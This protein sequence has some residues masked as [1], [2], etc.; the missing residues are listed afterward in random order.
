MADSRLGEARSCDERARFYAT[1]RAEIAG[2]GERSLF[3]YLKRA[4]DRIFR[5]GG[6]THDAASLL[7]QIGSFSGHRTHPCTK[8]RLMLEAGTGPG[9]HPLSAAEFAAYAPEAAPD[10]SLPVLAVARDQVTQ[11][12]SR[13]L[14][15]DYAGFFAQSFPDAHRAWAASVARLAGQGAPDRFVPIPIHPLQL[16]AIQARFAGPIAAGDILTGTGAAIVQRPTISFRTFSPVGRPAE[17]QVKTTLAILMTSEVRILSPARTFNAPVL[18]DLLLGIA[19][20]DGRLAGRFRLQP[21][22]AAVAWGRD[23]DPAS[24]DYRDGYHLGVILRR[25]P[26]PLLSAGEMA[27]PLNTLLSRSPAP[28]GAM[29]LTE[30]MREAGVGDSAAALA[31]FRHYAGIVLGVTLWMLARYG[32]SIEAHQQNTDLVFDGSGRLAALAYRD[33]SGGMEICEPMLIAAGHDIRPALHP[34]I[35]SLCGGIGLPI[36]QTMHTTFVSHL[37]PVSRLI[38]EDFGTGLP[39]LLAAMKEIIL[40]VLGDARRDLA[41]D[42]GGQAEPLFHDALAAIE[43]RILHAPVETKGLLQMR[44]A[45]SHDVTF[46]AIDNPLAGI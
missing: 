3:G 22:P 31:W 36:Q 17:P 43:Q 6:A 24:A 5:L 16:P 38:A 40:A 4:G 18:S 2:A 27:L 23:P 20:R 42:S 32:I 39:S 1:L 28:G 34:F 33:A 44:A 8:T 9:R 14:G 7:V 11:S 45:Q 15:C 10:V 41:R 29:L 19:S 30:I 37:F 46:T 35:R 12:V 13:A 21:D 26:A 25:N